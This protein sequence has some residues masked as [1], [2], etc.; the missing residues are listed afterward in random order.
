MARA[1]AKAKAKA[2]PTTSELVA[3]MLAALDAAGVD[4]TEGSG[5]G[6][7]AYAALRAG[8]MRDLLPP[9][10]RLAEAELAMALGVSRT[11]VRSALQVLLQEG[12]V[13][14]G[15]KRQIFVR[16]FTPDEQREAILLREAL[17][18]TAIAEASRVIELSEIDELRLV[19]MRQR[20][21]ADRGDI[22]AFIDL[23]DQF[24]LGIA[25]RARLPLLEKFLG[26]LSATIRL[27][28]LR[29]AM[30]EGRPSAVLDEHEAILVALE[31][32]DAK[33]AQAALDRHL[34][35]TYK[36]LGDSTPEPGSAPVRRSPNGARSRA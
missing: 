9:G 17:E 7:R 14:T 35:N 1:K 6:G 11:P 4:L 36:L 5:A 19:L 8:I 27:M 20:R 10:T 29:A 31:K 26:Q 16:V 2:P 15:A 18:R 32:R 23:D 12:L 30:H 33:A 34:S 25:Q 28:G 22:E 13:E 24:H 3:T 21:A